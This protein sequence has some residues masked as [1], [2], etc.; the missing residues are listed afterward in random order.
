MINYT[1][2]IYI[3]YRSG[4]IILLSGD[5]SIIVLSDQFLLLDSGIFPREWFWKMILCYCKNVQN[6]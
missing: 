2:R 3:I 1:D 6:R 4:D 5:E